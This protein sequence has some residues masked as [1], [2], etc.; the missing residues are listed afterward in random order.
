[1]SRSRKAQMQLPVAL[2]QVADGDKP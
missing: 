1:V 2:T